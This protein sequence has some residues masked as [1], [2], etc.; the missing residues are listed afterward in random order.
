[1]R[2]SSETSLTVCIP[3]FNHEKYIGEAIE[4]CLIQQNCIDKIMISDDGSS[5]GSLRVVERYMKHHSKV[6]LLSNAPS[7]N[8]GAHARLNLLIE[9]ATSEWICVLNSDDFLSPASL[10]NFQRFIAHTNCDA[11]FGV[12]KIVNS[13]SQCIGFKYPGSALQ[14]EIVEQ[15]LLN[16]AFKDSFWKECLHNQNFIATTSNF[17][18]KKSLW[19]KIGK[20]RSYRYVHDWDFFLRSAVLAKVVYNPQHIVNYRVH[21]SN[22]IKEG[23]LKIRSEVRLLFKL[24]Q[25]DGLLRLSAKEIVNPYLTAS[26]ATLR[27]PQLYPD[28]TNYFFNLKGGKYIYT[29]LYKNSL[30]IHALNATSSVD[31][32]FTTFTTPLSLT[33]ISDSILLRNAFLCCEQGHIDAIFQRIVVKDGT[34]EFNLILV[35]NKVLRDQ[36]V[37]VDHIRI[38]SCPNLVAAYT[39]SSDQISSLTSSYER[40]FHLPISIEVGEFFSQQEDIKNNLFPIALPKC[41]TSKQ[42][43]L[44]LTGVFAIGGVERVTI[45]VMNSLNHLFEFTILCTEFATQEQ[46]SLA[47]NAEKIGCHVYYY[48]QSYPNNFYLLVERLHNAYQFDLVWIINGSSLLAKYSR[49]FEN[50]IPTIKYIDNQVYDSNEGWIQSFDEFSN[51][52]NI[53]YVAINKKIGNIFKNKYNISENKIKLIYPCFNNNKYFLNQKLSLDDFKE[54]KKEAR[55]KLSLPIDSNIF[56]N[57]ARCDPQKNQM[58]FVKLAAR[59]SKKNKKS[60]FLIIGDGPESAK[61]DDAIKNLSS[62]ADVR[63]LPFLENL[64]DYY[65]A[66]NA[67]V[68]TSHFEGLPVVLLEATAMGLPTISTDV[69]DCLDFIDNYGVGK[70]FDSNGTDKDRDSEFFDFVENIDQ[71]SYNAFIASASVSVAHSSLTI[72]TSYKELFYDNLVDSN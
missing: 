55:L 19:E 68:I 21:N 16:T 57:C 13:E 38:I 71:Y 70:V 5:D 50:L 24:L 47:E 30:G 56:L 26:L 58:E 20:F 15:D 65:L 72:A 2:N 8:I 59:F 32:V 40:A 48:N 51:D 44:I 34:I 45:D 67:L 7:H 6:Q 46:G 35:K 33:N 42:R 53:S 60:L 18:F 52:K 49:N 61:L 14:Y 66:A 17:I 23:E 22:T 10:K 12:I 43:I 37:H 69:G 29:S 36:S 27:N 31:G 11:Y 41:V 64:Y 28:N 63:R 54:R 39:P 1:M 62:E 25:R 4:S 9:R 3:L